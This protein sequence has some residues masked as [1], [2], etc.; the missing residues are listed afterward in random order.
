[1]LKIPEL[2]SI[3]QQ[4]FLHVPN[5]CPSMECRENKTAYLK[6]VSL[7]ASLRQLSF[8]LVKRRA[9][10]AVPSRR[11]GLH[12]TFITPTGNSVPLTEL[13][14]QMARFDRYCW[15]PN[16]SAVSWSIWKKNQNILEAAQAVKS[17]DTNSS[18]SVIEIWWFLELLWKTWW[19]Y[20]MLNVPFASGQHEK[21]ENGMGMST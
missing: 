21:F 9:Y 4:T 2:H 3:S 11:P 14:W 20:E 15:A 6:H 18:T 7:Q 16:I 13:S 17:N 5:V 1:M 19:L 8:T 10:I 12:H